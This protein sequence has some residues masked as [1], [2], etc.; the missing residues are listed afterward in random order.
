MA[1]LWAAAVLMLLLCVVLSA[2]QV[3]RREAALAKHNGALAAQDSSGGA[4]DGSGDAS[5]RM[6]SLLPDRINGYRTVARHRVPGLGPT[7]VEAI[8]VP[9]DEKVAIGTPLNCYVMIRCPDAGAMTEELETLGGRYPER[10]EAPDI[11]VGAGTL[12]SATS[13]RS[14]LVTVWEQA[15]FL[16]QVDTRF[17]VATPVKAEKLLRRHSETVAMAVA[18]QIGR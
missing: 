6:L 14:V 16:V 7:T 17:T 18:Q 4:E 3:S 1:P 2:L 11:G 13:G 12:F 10:V 8:Y 15:G 9:E 5:R